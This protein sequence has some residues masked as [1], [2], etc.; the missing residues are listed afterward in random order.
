MA[1]ASTV[2]SVGRLMVGGIQ[3]ALTGR[4]PGTSYRSLISLFCSTGGRSSDALSRFVSIVRPPYRTRDVDGVLGHLDRDR[5]SAIRSDLDEN[6][7][8]VFDARLPGAVCDKLVAFS[9]TARCQVRSPAESGQVAKDIIVDT[10]DPSQ[11]IGTR[12]DFLTQDLVDNPDVQQIMAD[13]TLLAVAQTY[14][15]SR[16]ILDVL[17]MWWSAAFSDRP[18]A[19]AAQHFHFDMDRIKWLKFFI[20]LTDV[21]PENGPHCFVAGSH[22]TGGI[23]QSLLAK[24][25]SRLT[26]DEVSAVYSRDRF[27]EFAAPRGTIIAED[28]RGLHKGKNLERG[29]RLVLQVQFSNSLFGGYYPPTKATRVVDENLRAGVAAYP[30]IYANYI[31]R[32][33]AL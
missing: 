3:H 25:Y 9:R 33:A 13:A 2:I 32:S 30:S 27:I 29:D 21:T 14:L 6:G 7:Y 4:T 17:G 10:Y 11:L 8:H 1:M 26:D 5:L 23:P 31:D 12:Y 24:G 16:P 18:D 15:R 20:Y 28:T 22:R 19:E